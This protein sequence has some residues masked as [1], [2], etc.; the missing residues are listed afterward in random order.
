[1]SKIKVP[2][3]NLSLQWVQQRKELLPII[4]R[5][6]TKDNWIGG[7]EIEKFESKIATYTNTKYAVALNSGTDALTLGLYVLGIQPGDEVITPPNSFI[8]STAVI[9]HLGAKPIFV[10][11]KEDQNIDPVLIEK[12]ITRKTK[13]IMPVHLTGRIADMHPIMEISKKYSIPIIEDAAQSI[14]SLYYKK[15][16]GSFGL[17]G[18]FSA[19]PLKNLNAIGDAGYLTTNNKEI[20]IKVKDLSNHGMTNRT[21]IKQFGFVSRMDNIQATILNFRLKNLKKVIKLRRKNVERYNKYL[22]KNY[23]FIPSEKKYEFNTYHTFVVQVLRRRDELKNFLL[24]NGINTAIHYP[25][26]IHLQPASKKLNY[27]VGDFIIAEDQAN[28]ILTL[29]IH[30]NLNQKTIKRISDL[31]NYFFTTI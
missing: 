20:Y 21:R 7:R 22:N 17:V 26:P 9:V 29:P 1:M 11:V 28:K 25:I 5:V 27:K 6:L 13:A 18:C 10:D 12:S 23:I 31:I 15:P 24:K 14:G 4:D 3:V 30:Q 19:H 8:A 2:Y 16:A